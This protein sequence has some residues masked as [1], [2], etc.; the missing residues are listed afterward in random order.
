MDLQSIIVAIA[1]NLWIS[2]PAFLFIISVII[3]VHE[4]GHFIAA[5]LCGV[6]VSVFSLGFGR[7]LAAY[8]D[9]NGT[10]WR[11]ALIPLGG[12][13]KFVDDEN[14]ASVPTTSETVEREHDLA[15]PEV[16][17]GF[18]H[19]KPVWQRAIIAAAGPVA[20]FLLAIVV[21]ALVDMTFGERLSPVRIDTV[22]PG[23]AAEKAGLK[24]GDIVLAVD[25]TPLDSFGKLKLIVSSSPDRQLTLTI[26]RG[27]QHQDFKV[28]PALGEDDDLLGGKVQIG[29][30]GIKQNQKESDFTIKRYGLVEALIRGS[31]QVELLLAASVRGLWD[32]LIM[33][34]SVSQL[35]GPTK[36]FEAA[37]KVAALGFEPLMSLLA[38]VSVAIGFAN[39]LPIPILDG[40]HLVFYAVEAVRGKPM[41]QRTQEM[42]FR[43]GFAVVLMLLVFTTVNHVQQL[44]GRMAG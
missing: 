27:G 10:R 25:G 43:V 19:S 22:I 28:T 38:T 34:Q 33:R 2:I 39:L 7:E 18:Y 14:A 31:Q 40:G 44:W 5:R 17:A 35:A 3:V 30:I 6:T 4:F 8:T 9:R 12:Y 36:L 15:P 13:V 1:Q 23:G 29:L 21:F 32:L 20:N 37:G 41:S 26:D 16:R 24:A 42:A 11:I